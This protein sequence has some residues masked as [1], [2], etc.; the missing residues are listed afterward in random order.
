MPLIFHEPLSYINFDAN[1]SNGKEEPSVNLMLPDMV[2]TFGVAPVS[3]ET[4]ARPVTPL[5]VEGSVDR[6]PAHMDRVFVRSS[7]SFMP[8]LASEA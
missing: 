8:K 5:M 3:T 6:L 1:A 4:S 7:P 2:Y